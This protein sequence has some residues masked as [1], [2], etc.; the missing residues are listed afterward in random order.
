M[1]GYDNR[2]L[3]WPLQYR[4]ALRK[5]V[6]DYAFER[7]MMQPEDFGTMTHWYSRTP[8][9]F[10]EKMNPPFLPQTDASAFVKCISRDISVGAC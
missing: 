7:G 8:K 2:S 9:Q 3:F 5:K 1:E 4:S 6:M 10:L